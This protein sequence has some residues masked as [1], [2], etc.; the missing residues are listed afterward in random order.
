MTEFGPKPEIGLPP[1]IRRTIF[2]E[3]KPFFSRAALRRA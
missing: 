2:V 3:R 1:G